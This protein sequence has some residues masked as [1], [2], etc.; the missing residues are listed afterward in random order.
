MPCDGTALISTTTYRFSYFVLHD[1]ETTRSDAEKI[2]IR[3]VS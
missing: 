2:D 3:Y 1:V